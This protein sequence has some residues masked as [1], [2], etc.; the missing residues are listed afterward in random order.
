MGSI[1]SYRLQSGERRYRARYR[2]PENRQR[3]KAGFARKNDAAN[4]LASI[5]VNSAKGEYV[6]PRDGRETLASFG[7]SWLRNQKARLK[8]STFRSIDSSWRIHVV[9]R[10]G[11]VPIAKIRPSAVDLW[12]AELCQELSP[13]SVIRAHGVLSAVLEL[14][15][16]DS[17]ISQNPAKGSSL[18]RKIRAQRHYLTH[19][20]VELLAGFSGTHGTLVR[21]LSYTGLRW[22]EVIGLRVK[23]LD[24]LRRRLQIRVN[25][26]WVGGTVEIGLPKNHQERSVPYPKFL[27]R[28]L[29]QLT[30]GKGPESLLFGTGERY[31]RPPDSRRGWWVSA[32]RQAQ[33]VDKTFPSLTRHDLRHTAASLAVSAGA[34]IKALQRMLGHASASMTLDTY[35]DLF[36]E[37]LDSVAERLDSD[38]AQKIVGF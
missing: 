11:A 6:D 26:V 30:A 36:D 31:L 18:P 7:V 13:S 22:G 15:A 8:P 38:R 34:N 35:A 1:E 9:P 10:F 2:D 3:E 37:D 21:T 33:A 14:A 27:D 16:R 12:V 5:T 20:Q 29:L 32:M 19:H 4:Y 17:R 24:G 28:S 25:A 23:D